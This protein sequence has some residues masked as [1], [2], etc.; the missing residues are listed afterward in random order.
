MKMTTEQERA[1]QSG[2]PVH[3]QR[4]GLDCV[5]IRADL[6]ERVATLFDSD[7]PLPDNCLQP[8]SGE[9]P[10]KPSA[11]PWTQETNN[12][13]C[14]LIDKDIAG[15]I[16]ETERTELAELQER[17]HIFLDETAPPP[18]KGAERLHQDLLQKKLE[19]RQG[20]YQD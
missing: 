10:G 11:K 13:R 18:I 2:Q 4:E 1:V 7:N 15:T 12:R 16:G 19:Q 20:R 14:D 6:F 9:K 8:Q 5:V 17:F 3:L